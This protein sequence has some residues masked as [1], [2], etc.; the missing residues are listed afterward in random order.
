M[1]SYLKIENVFSFAFN[2][3]VSISFSNRTSGRIYVVTFDH[4]VKGQAIV[5]CDVKNPDATYLPE[6]WLK[7]GVRGNIAPYIFDLSK[8]DIIYGGNVPWVLDKLADMCIKLN[9]KC[10]YI[11]GSF[12]QVATQITGRGYIPHRVC[13]IQTM[14]IFKAIQDPFHS[15]ALG[16]KN[17][18][19]EK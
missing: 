6:I 11:I 1:Q 17:T 19:G 5:L 2:N 18:G 9:V 15:L 7:Y 10:I 8:C 16:I 14:D 4:M 13:N 3:S 12:N